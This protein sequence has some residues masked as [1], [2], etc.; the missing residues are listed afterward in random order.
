[1]TVKKMERIVV[2]GS[3][4][5]GLRT[6]EALR[7]R[8]HEGEIV[9][10]SA[11]AEWPYD[12]PPLSKQFLKGDWELDRLSLRRQ[13]FDDLEVDWRLGVAADSLDLTHQ[14]VALSTGESLKYDGLVLAT[15]ASP[16]MIPGMAGREGVH[17]LR[18]LEDARGLRRALDQGG[19]LAVIGA[20]FIGMEAAASARQRGLEVVVVEALE[21]PLLRGLGRQLG[22]LVGQR[23]RDRGVD[24]RCGVGVEGLVGEGSVS[25]LALSDGSIIEAQ[26]VL[27]GIGVVPEVAWLEGS[28]LDVENGILCDATGATSAEGVVAVGD[29]ARWFS[30]R[31]GEAIRHE[32]WTSAVEQSD[33]AAT[34]LLCGADGAKP[35]D[36]VAYVWSDQFEMRLALV[37]EPAAGDTLHVCHGALDEDRFLVLVGSQGRLVGAVSMKRPRP[38]NIARSLLEKGASLD[39][40]IEAVA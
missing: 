30:P 24:L 20:G 12:R 37:G 33:V 34:R 17:V 11:E 32:H 10:L 29:C 14:E 31:R 6:I 2:V 7:R 35:L 25:G 40:A 9:A 28:G 21:A 27:V 19:R 5:A 26:N 4:L 23:H 13:G 1:M 39:E 22:E 36:S 8:G 15:G 16:R 3:S 18:S 38:L